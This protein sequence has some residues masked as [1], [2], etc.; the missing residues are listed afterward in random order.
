MIDPHIIERAGMLTQ[1][2]GA[3]PW[4]MLGLVVLGFIGGT[5]SGFI[6]SGGA[7]LMTPGMMNLG[8]PGVIAVASNIAHKFG[9]AMMGSKKHSELGNVDKK[10]G[11]FLL[12]TASLGISLA[13]FVNKFFFVKMGKDGSDLYVSTFFVVVL[14]IIGTFM[15]KDALRSTRQPGS[16]PSDK[17]LKISRK[18]QFKPMIHFKVANVDISLYSILVVGLAT[19]YM[20]G[21]IG[22][23][24]FIGVPAMIY[25]FGVPTALAAGTELFLAV[26]TGGW[27]TF[28]YALSGYVDLRLVLLLYAGSLPGIYFGAVATKVVKE[29]YIRLVTAV[30]ILLCVVSRLLAMPVNCKN[31]N[32]INLDASTVSALEMGSKIFLFG[33]GLIATFLILFWTFRAKVREKGIV[34][35]SYSASVE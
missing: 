25:L 9:K 14:S 10:L 26:F 34:E 12:I 13:V 20:A 4:Y 28:N 8:V 15:L 5:I 7:F 32:W 27:G 17:F 2:L 24:G 19:G 11:I 1:I 18:F 30:L 29:L 21:T 6:G 35:V 31:L 33:S 22:V 16:G 3:H 23:G